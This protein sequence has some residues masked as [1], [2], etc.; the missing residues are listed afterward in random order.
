MSALADSSNYRH[1]RGDRCIAVHEA[2]F[3]SSFHGFP[4]LGGARENFRVNA[5]RKYTNWRDALQHT[6]SLLVHEEASA[7]YSDQRTHDM[8]RNIHTLI[9]C[10]HSC[11][12][13]R[14]LL[15][16]CMLHQWRMQYRW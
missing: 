11:T 12:C 10:G 9:R 2:R 6:D 4:Q 14:A 16:V 5:V 3:R 1:S 15:S 7:Q 13:W 8:R